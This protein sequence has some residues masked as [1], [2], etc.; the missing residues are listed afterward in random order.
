MIL[1]KMIEPFKFADLIKDVYFDKES[2]S[3]HDIEDIFNAY[4]TDTDCELY[5]KIANKIFR[6]NQHD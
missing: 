6:R 3:M 1:L 5:N 2:I 4:C